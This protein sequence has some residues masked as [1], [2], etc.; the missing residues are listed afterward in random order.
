M[1]SLLTAKQRLR[2]QIRH[3]RAIQEYGYQPQALFWSSRD[4]QRIRF[5]QLIS[6]FA[7]GPSHQTDQAWSVLDVGCGFGD[8]KAY[9][10]EQGLSVDYQGIDISPDM[11]E[12]ARYQYPG[13]AV[14]CADIFDLAPAPESY[15]FVLLSGALNEVVENAV[16]GTEQHSGRY[17]KAV[18][19]AL[20]EACRHGVAFNLL[21]AREDWTR[22]RPDLQ[23]FLPEHIVAYCQ[24]FAHSVSWQDGYLDNDFTVYLL[25]E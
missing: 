10:T 1:S 12:S 18:I 17:A 20:Y 24:T 13:I 14:Q 11:V 2:I 25:K 23:S 21:D 16:E 4:I 7:D 3:Q 15:D 5:A 8:L 22:N 6:I 9:L 19:R